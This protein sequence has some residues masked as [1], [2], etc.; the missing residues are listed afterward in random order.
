MPRVNEIV[1]V[2]LECDH[3]KKVVRLVGYGTYLGVDDSD[4]DEPE[5][6]IK[7][8]S[9]RLVYGSEVEAFASDPAV[10]RELDRFRDAGWAVDET[11]AVESDL[12]Q[13]REVRR[14]MLEAG[15]AAD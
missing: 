3:E 13:A 14:K 9:G 7:L 2:L 11:P 1:G 12:V 6:V 4:P 5:H 15:Q 10:R 8:D